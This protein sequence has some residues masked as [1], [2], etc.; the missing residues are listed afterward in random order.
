MEI[1]I[2]ILSLIILIEIIFIVKKVY[3]IRL[4]EQKIIQTQ[5][6][7]NKIQEKINSFLNI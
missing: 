4:L 1:A 7:V 3:N 2:T 5:T 6:K